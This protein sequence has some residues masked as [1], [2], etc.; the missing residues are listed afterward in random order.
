VRISGRGWKKISAVG[1][2]TLSPGIA[3]SD[4]TVTCRRVTQHFSLHEGDIDGERCAACLRDL[5]GRVRGKIVLLWDGLAV[6]RAPAVKAVLERHPRVTVHRLPS[7]APELNP[8]EPMWAHAK[9]SGLRGCAPA[10][11]VD[12]EIEAAC[13]LEDIAQSQ[14]LLRSFFQATPL[15]IPGITK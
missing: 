8:V 3:R 6:H 12:L 10:D 1:V 7:Y 14:A 13:V 11:A 2:L 5:L 4:G 15:T 9:G